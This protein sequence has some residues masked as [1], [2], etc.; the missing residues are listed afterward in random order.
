M[1]SHIETVEDYQRM[2]FAKY[3]VHKYLKYCKENNL[4][5]YWDCMV[6]NIGSYKTAEGHGY[7]R[8][9]DYPLF[10]FTNNTIIR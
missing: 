1:E 4:I 10:S 5:P 6:T 7:K 3:L 8:A 2:G 9:F